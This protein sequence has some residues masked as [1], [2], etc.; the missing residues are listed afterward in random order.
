[1]SPRFPYFVKK[2][3]KWIKYY[4]RDDIVQSVPNVRRMN[5][6]VVSVVSIKTPKWSKKKCI[7][8]FLKFRSINCIG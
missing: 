4:G 3:C 8:K 6:T 5:T 2:C 7:C 1:M